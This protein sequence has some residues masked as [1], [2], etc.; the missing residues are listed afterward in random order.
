MTAPRP[1]TDLVDDLTDKLLR[2]VAESVRVE[3]A[4]PFSVVCDSRDRDAWLQARR[5]LPAIGASESAYVLGVARGSWSSLLTLWAEK[6][7]RELPKDN[8]SEAQFWGLELEDGIIRGYAKRSGRYTMPF[9]LLIRS[10]RWP[11]LFAT[12]DAI[13]TD[14]PTAGAMKPK[15][16]RTIGHIRAAL[17]KGADTSE[18]VPE[19]VHRMQGWW[20]LQVKNIGFGAAEHWADG[21]PLYYTVQCIHEALVFG[22]AATTAGALVAGQQ[23]AWDDV[24]ADPS[25]ILPRQIVNLCK[26]FMDDYVTADREPTAD[27]SERARE[28][29]AALYPRENPGSHVRFGNDVAEMADAID[30]LKTEQK[31]HDKAISA[32]ENQIRQMMQHHERCT[33]PDGSGYTLKANVNGSRVLLRKRAPKEK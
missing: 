17:R 20:P 14:N 6:T 7:G 21:V 23:L 5:D 8:Q 15:I 2:D 12:P 1:L 29:I 30:Q 19:L 9:G 3:G 25:E 4:L 10:T 11:W 28:T 31:A 22:A 24:H 32:Y 33:L 13:V 27:G 18:L 26:R 16:S